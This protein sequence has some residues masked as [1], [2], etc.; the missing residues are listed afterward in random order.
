MFILFAILKIGFPFVRFF[1]TVAWKSV[2]FRIK[3]TTLNCE[4]LKRG[5]KRLNMIKTHRFSILLSLSNWYLPIHCVK[6][7][8]SKT[9][10]EFCKTKCLKLSFYKCIHFLLFWLLSALWIYH[11]HC[12]PMP[13]V[14]LYLSFH[15]DSLRH[16]PDFPHFLYFHRDSRPRF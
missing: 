12:L 5:T 16:R 10:N 7:V 13:F 9:K 4:G 1:K 14:L 11:V 6:S 8:Q 15:L 3:S 2:V